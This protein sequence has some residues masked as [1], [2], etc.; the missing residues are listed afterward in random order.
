MSK[1]CRI[2]G[3]KNHADAGGFCK[4]HFEQLDAMYLEDGRSIATWLIAVT[5][6]VSFPTD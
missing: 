5:K 6:E 3:C 1:T 2:K 4:P